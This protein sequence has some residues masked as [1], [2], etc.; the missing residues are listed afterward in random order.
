MKKNFALFLILTSLF[1]SCVTKTTTT[2]KGKGKH[3][4]TTTSEKKVLF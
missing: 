1:I 3:K 4:V 2:T